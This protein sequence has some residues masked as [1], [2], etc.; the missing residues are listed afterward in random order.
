MIGS[1]F[2]YLY[3]DA[4]SME[5]QIK[6]EF[7]TKPQMGMH[8]ALRSSTPPSFATVALNSTYLV[9]QN[10]ENSG[11]NCFC[12]SKRRQR[13]SERCLSM[14]MKPWKIQTVMQ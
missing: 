3:K 7:P 5:T 2:S 6:A 14:V 13:V 12:N 11:I 10:G 4:Y 1:F 9:L 8:Q